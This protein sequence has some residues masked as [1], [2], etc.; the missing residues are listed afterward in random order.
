MLFSNL[1]RFENELLE[2]NSDREEAPHG[3]ANDV[4]YGDFDQQEHERLH[5]LYIFRNF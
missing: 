1:S 5:F 2:R 4:D 3:N